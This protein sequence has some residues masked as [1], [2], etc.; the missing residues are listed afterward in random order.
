MRMLN[1]L[2]D[3]ARW[4]VPGGVAFCLMLLLVDLLAFWAMGRRPVIS[5]LETGVSVWAL[6][7]GSGATYGARWLIS[8]ENV[9]RELAATLAVVVLMSAL[10]PWMN[11]LARDADTPVAPTLVE[12]AEPDAVVFSGG[13]L[14][15]AD[16]D[17]ARW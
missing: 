1:W 7:I 3:R 9:R 4:L 14:S 6:L 8:H 13:P 15:E 5:S 2:S 16:S 12:S 17:T 11:R 10:H